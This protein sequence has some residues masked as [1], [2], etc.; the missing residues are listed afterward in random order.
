MTHPDLER[1]QKK[2]SLRLRILL[3]LYRR[4]CD[5][6]SKVVE[7]NDLKQWFDNPDIEVQQELGYLNHEGLIE[8]VTHVHWAITHSG[9]KETE[10]TIQF[11]DKP[12]PHF[13]LSVI[14]H[15]HAPVAVVQNGDNTARVE[16]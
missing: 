5:G 3:L 16:R 4:Y 10:H 1:L 13:L 2:Q 11:P 14:Q 9:I 12:T 7:H 15:Y 8:S 6:I